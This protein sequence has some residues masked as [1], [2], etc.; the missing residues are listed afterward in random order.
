M[1]KNWKI[2]L[3]IEENDKLCVCVCIKHPPAHTSAH[4][5][6]N[7]DKLKMK[8]LKT[9]MVVI[10]I[11]FLQIILAPLPVWT[12]CRIIF[13]GSLVVW[14]NHIIS[15]GQWV[16]SRNDIPHFRAR[17]PEH[18]IFWV[19]CFLGFFPSASVTGDVQDGGCSVSL[20]HWEIPE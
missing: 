7:F 14:W 9:G 8:W 2:K 19:R 18:L 1:K 20:N 10:G 16:V 11:I 13:P 3:S 4:T 15:F 6:N 17:G 5:E 12:H